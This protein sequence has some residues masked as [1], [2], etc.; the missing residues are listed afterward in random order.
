L[1]DWWYTMLQPNPHI[2][3]LP[4]AVHGGID[5]EE[6]ADIGLSPHEILDFSVNTNPFGP[7]PGIEKALLEAT[8]DRYPDSNAGEL[9]KALAKRHGISANT[10]CVGSGSTEIIRAI[11]TAYFSSRDVV[12]IPKPTYGEYEIACRLVDARVIA[13]PIAKYPDFQ[14]DVQKTIALIKRH[15]PKGIFLC[16]PN[17]PTG[18][19]L[20]EDVVRQVVAMARDSLLIIDE[21]YIAFTDAAWNSI[22]LINDSNVV[23]VRSMTKDCALA[24]LRIGYVIARPGIIAVLR[25]VLPPWNVNA[26]AQG[27]ALFCLGIDS[28]LEGCGAKIHEAKEFLMKEMTEIGFPIVPSQTSFFLVKVGDATA[29]RQSLLRRKILVRDCTSFGLPDYI[30][31]APRTLSECKVLIEGMKG[32]VKEH[33]A[34]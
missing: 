4:A 28:Y 14:F 1:W 7:P 6:I 26:V 5:Y 23:I 22:R 20:P 30:R 24:G 17:N 16:N 12:L 34:S 19:Y 3:N 31:I 8:I 10:I 15:R 11:A 33:H 18:R 29:I 32:V 25:R 9:V 27:A 13:Q 21:A 2:N